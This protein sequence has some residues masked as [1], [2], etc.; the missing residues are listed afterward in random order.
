MNMINIR[1]IRLGFQVLATTI[2]MFQMQQSIKQYLDCPYA[3][4]K[5]I[6]QKSMSKNMPKI[7]ICQ[8]DQY[9]Y[10][11]SKEFGYTWMNDLLIG[12]IHGVNGTATWQSS[13]RNK[14]YKTLTEQL[15]KYNYSNLDTNL[16]AFP[17]FC[18]NNGFCKELKVNQSQTKEMVKSAVKIKVVLAD[19]YNV[20]EIKIEESLTATAVIGPVEDSNLFEWADYR[21]GYTLTDSRIRDGIDCRDYERMN[22]KYGDCIALELQVQTSDIFQALLRHMI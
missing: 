12:R 9:D 4:I 8:I 11:K 21:V 19:P 6:K 10:T 20:N 3:M 17:H 1:F 14:K 16:T 15:F 5:S 22:T 2:F 13:S 18:I 7:Y